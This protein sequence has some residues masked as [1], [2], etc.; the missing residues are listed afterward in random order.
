MN[1][2]TSFILIIL[3]CIFPSI[4]VQAQQRIDLDIEKN[5][6]EPLICIN[7]FEIN[8]KILNLSYR[9]NRK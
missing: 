9:N 5:V 2:K 1:M 3:L 7:E 6:G 4:R 8:E